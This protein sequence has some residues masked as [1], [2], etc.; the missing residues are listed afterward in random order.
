M[1]IL[2]L[3]LS[4]TSSWGNG[5]ATTYRG[6]MRELAARGHNVLFLERDVPWYAMNRDLPIPPYGRT[7]LYAGPDDLRDRFITEIREADVTVVGSY[8]TLGKLRN[9]DYE[10][11]R[12][13]LI[14]QYNLYL[15]FSG[16]PVLETI[17]R[18]YGSPMARPFYCS[19]DPS[20]Y[21]PERCETK[22]DLGYMGTYS[23]DRQPPLE[24]LMLNT[25][26]RWK[27][28]RFIVAGPLYPEGVH[29]PKNVKRIEHLPPAGHRDFYNIQRFTLN[30]TRA[31]MIRAGYSPSVRLFEA[32]A[33]ATPVISDYWTGLAEFF[34]PGR[35][36][37]VSRSTEET[38]ACLRIPEEQ[39]IEIGVHAR[40]RILSTHT[41]GRR[42]EE[43]ERYIGEALQS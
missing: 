10:Y 6:L 25:A 27:R 41:A 16:G 38:L 29:W 18:V 15:S 1:N 33:C 14:P 42:A 13:D 28:G 40:K 36:I 17:K 39:R 3:G 35:D 23:D 24:E 12:P 5:H 31:D 20:L 19:V 7:E 9:G 4:I 30:I 43:L 34:Q 26:R 2:F 11:L 37:L 8:V 32:A 22:Y 21:F